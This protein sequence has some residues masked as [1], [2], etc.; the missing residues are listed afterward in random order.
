MEPARPRLFAELC[1]GSAAVTL[2]LLG[3]AY[4]RPPISYQGS[5]RGY[6]AAILGAMG[7]RSG[8]G[9]DSV[10]LCDPGPWS[11]VWAC[12]S[13][14]AGRNAVADTIRG[15]SSEEPRALW[16]RLRARGPLEGLDGVAQYVM[17][18][19]SNRLINGDWFDGQWRNT[20]QGG[21]T[22]GG[23]D[24]ATPAIDVAGLV[25]LLGVVKWP[26]PLRIVDV[27]AAGIDPAE[28]AAWLLLARWSFN[29]KGPAHGYGGPGSIVSTETS[30]WTTAQRDKAIERPDLIKRVTQPIGW[31]EMAVALDARAPVP[32][33]L[34]PGCFVYIDPPYQ[35]TTGYAHDL[36]RADVITIA[37][38]WN[39]AGAV[40]CVSEAEPVEL[41][42]WYSIEITDER[43]GQSR[44]FS[45]QKSEWLTMNREPQLGR[46]G[47]G[48]LFDE[49]AG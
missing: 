31:P 20:G 39:A 43:V 23:A 35:H 12:L 37:E 49:V 28:V 26:E 46:I 1:C 17:L 32:D 42:G 44:T 36:P 11:R 38:R 9:A 45:K 27:S 2:R 24:F 40:V 22:H 7:L 13:T 15:W 29:Q 8:Q 4:A 47:S 25:R 14:R 30:N 18:C 21:T 19:A 10:L 34:P 41:P 16:E 5:K 33:R 48:R 3:G 6:A